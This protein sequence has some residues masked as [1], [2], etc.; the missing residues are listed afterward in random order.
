MQSTVQ[1]SHPQEPETASSTANDS[2]PVKFPV[3]SDHP[4]KD[5]AKRAN[6]ANDEKR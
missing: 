3:F 5:K 6:K 1:F 4:D 2:E